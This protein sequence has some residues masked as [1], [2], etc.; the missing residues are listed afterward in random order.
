MTHI[1]RR[2]FLGT[3]GAAVAWTFAVPSFSIGKA[4]PS[5]NSKLN[6]AMIGVGGIGDMALDGCQ[7]ENIVALCDIDEGYAKGPLNKEGPKYANAKNAKT[8]ADFRVMFDKM[9]KEIDGV[10]IN[11]PDHTHF[12]ATMEAMRRGIHV[13]TQKPLTHDIWQSRTLIKAV[14]EYNKVITNMGNQ[15]HTGDGIRDMKEWYQAGALG[16]VREVHLGYPGPNYG[17][18]FA[19]PDERVHEKEECPE[20]IHWDY[21]Y[22]QAPK[23]DYSRH[24]QPCK[25]RSF[26]DY[27]TGMLGDWFC[28]TGDGPVWVLDLYDPIEIERVEVKESR[29]GMIPHSCVVRWKFPQ[30]GTAEPCDMYWYDG[31][32]NGG[33]PIKSPEDWSYGKPPRY[34]SFWFADKANAFMGDRS[35]GPRLCDREKMRALNA[36]KPERTLPRCKSYGPHRE[37]IDAIKGGPECGSRFEVSARLTETCLLGVLAE[38][39]GGVIKWDEKNMKV[40][41]RPELNAYVKEPVRNDWEAYGEDLWKS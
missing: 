8:F 18:Y 2:K 22:G 41:N 9:G 32:D 24:K 13:C 25:W 21:W 35:N 5:P 30:R 7:N 11:T 1:G 36:N 14:K 23:C 15:G 16:Q 28:H 40:T 4:G 3:T 10:C 17:S 27:G 38:R 6:I 33:T 20:H 29:P 39:F 12:A 31:M 34:G 19:V 37:W 26:W